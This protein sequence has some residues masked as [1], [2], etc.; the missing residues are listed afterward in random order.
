MRPERL[1]IHNFGPFRR[2]E[3]V[4]FSV[5]DDIFLVTG[6]TGSGKTT[7]F[8][9][10]C[11]ALYG[12][13]PGSRQ[14]HLS[15]LR[16]DFAEPGEECLVSLEFTLGDTR[17]R[18]DRSPRQEKLK[19]R[20][21]GTLTV[22]ESAALYKVAAEGLLPL[23]AKKTEADEAVREL[24][25]LNKE[26]FFKIVLLPQGEFTE[27]LKQNT[28]DRQKV[29]G[30]LFPA[31]WAVRVRERVREQALEGE[32]ELR[33]AERALGEISKR[34]DFSQAG[35]L[36][37]KADEAVR[38][39][40]AR[41]QA[42]GEELA[43]FKDFR[44]I[45]R[46]EQEAENRL[47]EL[48]AENRRLHDQEGEIQE[49][50]QRLALSRQAKPLGQ[51]LR[52]GETQ[53]REAEAASREAEQA[54]QARQAAERAA[55]EAER[56]A[57]GIGALEGEA[58][59][60]REN[61]PRFLA[62][63]EEAETYTRALQ[64]MEALAGRLRSLAGDIRSLESR[65][66]GL[67]GELSALE[68]LARQFDPLDTRFEEAKAVMDRL[69][70]LKHIAD[71]GEALGKERAALDDRLEALGRAKAE[72]DSRLPVLEAEVEGLR[73]EQ[74]V[75][76]R[77]NR[78]AYLG[79]ELRPGEPCP[80]CGAREHPLP[81]AAPAP[82]FGIRERIAAQEQ[83]L[84]DARRDMASREA[85]KRSG[86]EERRRIRAKLQA[87]G[88]EAGETRSG[89]FHPAPS[90]AFPGAEDS[91]LG[92]FFAQGDG[93]PE[94][95]QCAALLEA[96][97]VQV[98][99]LLQARVEAQRAGVRL[100]E[101]HRELNE[102]Q[103]LLGIREK[104]HAACAEKH[105]AFQDSAEKMRLNRETLGAEF[106]RLQTFR[107]SGN[108]AVQPP[109][110]PRLSAPDMVRELDRRIRLAETA[111]ATCRE[112]RER[113]GRELAAAQARES[114]GQRALE[115]A[116]R[117]DQEAAAELAAVL[118]PSPFASAEA[119][120]AAILD[121]ETEAA[122]DDRI[123]RWKEAR[124]RIAS[125]TEEAR[126]NQEKIAQERSALGD[127]PQ[128]AAVEARLS[129]LMEEQEA[130]EAERD[131]ASGERAALERD[132]L[133]LQAAAERYETLKGQ[134]GRLTALADDLTGK[135]PKKK[136]FDAWLLGRHLEE[137]AA[138]ASRRLEKMSE[139]RYSLLLQSDAGTG[140][141]KA[142]LDL[143]VF[144]AYTGK[145]RPCATL[146]GGESFMAAIS[147]ALG[148]ADS[149]QNRSGGIQLNAVF[150]DEGFGSL[151]DASLDRALV[152]LDELREH[153][154]VGLISH[155]GELRSRIPSHIEV[156]KSGSGSRI[157]IARRE[158]EG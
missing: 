61:R 87:L 156:I 150:I 98:N 95:E 79:A 36:R 57:A 21:S 52:R 66:T 14:G 9:A 80:V 108:G 113:T 101:L 38:Q 78:A 107:Q 97:R 56:Q 158:A 99:A 53:R 20:G 75:F 129:A 59:T 22:E 89:F 28:A 39:A 115:A 26:E 114:G 7:I 84:K 51:Y 112:N 85:E 44:H 152:I 29:L 54:R 118:A 93:L 144:D 27:F 32:A 149:I 34:I 148:L 42:L 74:E 88:Q 16:S 10:L 86:E 63:A 142:G 106:S 120:R 8:D 119:V 146:S 4:D 151:D 12:A 103:K 135:N 128:A 48:E 143:A 45:R 133:L 62:L 31:D 134:S 64:E 153:R 3:L 2:R 139:S 157:R 67:E 68:T 69:R 109:E 136:S 138:Y 13:V 140:R 55:E 49:A 37:E 94:A 25:G 104:D 154:M 19:K 70:G 122:L 131:R 155:V 15:R 76:E 50:E 65:R 91:P 73:K 58:Q 132:A 90:D 141:G 5:L 126:R 81:A 72:L 147:L 137:I 24:L 18:I 100:A 40:K 82:L 127:V 71:A 1:E 77:A 116:L 30:K 117:R 121:G 23:N 46:Q 35:A 105:R 111:L 17:Y 92:E 11:F 125:L 47:A 96:Q 145:C 102:V 110:T 60:L 130:A 123:N 33:E 41:L 43:R 124:S 83:A 6:K